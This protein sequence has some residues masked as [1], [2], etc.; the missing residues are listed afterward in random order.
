MIM[1]NDTNEIIRNRSILDNIDNDFEDMMHRTSSIKYEI[2]E[3]TCLGPHKRELLDSIDGI[4]EILK[5]V[6]EPI[7]E[8]VIVGNKLCDKYDEIMENLCFKLK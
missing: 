7:E 2:D 3:M 8:Y 6:Y 1:V 5:E 4:E